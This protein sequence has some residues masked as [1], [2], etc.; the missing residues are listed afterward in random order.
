MKRFLVL[1]G[2]AALF[3]VAN[4]A[5]HKR[6]SVVSEAE[7]ANV[8]KAQL[9]SSDA[10]PTQTQSIL[11]HQTY[12]IWCAIPS[13]YKT[14]PLVSGVVDDGGI[15][16]ANDSVPA[17]TLNPAGQANLNGSACQSSGSIS[18]PRFRFNS[19]IHTGIWAVAADGGNPAC[20]VSLVQGGL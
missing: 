13:C 3:A 8:W 19:G 16:C 10:G 17:C 11:A 9:T 2:I 12:E 5:A 7:A 4:Y 6:V 18:V 15:S 1:V 20:N 14:G